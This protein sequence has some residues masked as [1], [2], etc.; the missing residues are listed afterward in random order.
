MY[1]HSCSVL[2]QDLYQQLSYRCI[3][4]QL[5]LAQSRRCTRSGSFP[6]CWYSDRSYRCQVW[7]DTRSSLQDIMGMRRARRST[8]D[9]V[10]HLSIF[11]HP[12]IPLHLVVA[13]YQEDRCTWR[14][15]SGSCRS[16]LS[17][18]SHP[19]PQSTRPGLLKDNKMWPPKELSILC[20]NEF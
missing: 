16:C 20:L 2:Q 12:Y 3:Q 14:F 7:H 19:D 15:Q 13:A 9:S 5:N 18:R 4:S 11:T 10:L 8:K 6:Q 17:S 1:V